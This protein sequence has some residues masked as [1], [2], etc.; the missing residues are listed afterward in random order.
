MHKGAARVVQAFGLAGQATSLLLVVGQ[1]MNHRLALIRQ[2]AI[3]GIQIAEDMHKGTAPLFAFPH[4]HLQRLLLL[5]HALVFA[6]KSFKS[7]GVRLQNL[8]ILLRYVHLLCPRLTFSSSR[9]RYS[10]SFSNAIILS[11]RPTTTSSNF[12]RSRIFSCSS[13]F[14]SSRSRTTFS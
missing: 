13:A 9:L 3:H 14:D 7:G 4:A 11:S 10:I 1:N 6:L 12:S 2:L 5:E 8:G